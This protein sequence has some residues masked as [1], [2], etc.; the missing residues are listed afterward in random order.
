MT[1]TKTPDSMVGLMLPSGDYLDFSDPSACPLD[2]DTIAYALSNIC[3]FGGHCRPFYSVAQHSV[4]VSELV[5]PEHQLEALLHD[6]AEAF[7]GDMVTPL[8]A[9]LPEYKRIE[10]NIESHIREQF[11]LPSVQN[12]LIKYAD[13][14]AFV[15]ERRDLMPLKGGIDSL[16]TVPRCNEKVV[17]L[18]SVQAYGLFIARYNELAA[19]RLRR[20]Y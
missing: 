19:G 15:T 4:L 13:T 6:A 17:P 5:P 10:H 16:A 11:R 14:V 12:P 1:G 8:K 7:I 20:A 18:P 2:I 3:R 9:M